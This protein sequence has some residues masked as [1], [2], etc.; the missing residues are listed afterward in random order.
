MNSFSI[1]PQGAFTL[2]ADPTNT[3]HAA[4]RHTP[5]ITHYLQ[6]LM[7]RRWLIVAC[8]AAALVVGVLATLLATPQFTATTQIEINREGARILNNVQNVEPETTT[9]DQEFYQTQ[10]TILRSRSLA[11]RVVKQLRLADDRQFF[12]TTGDKATAASFSEGAGASASTRAQRAVTA[13]KIVLKHLS[14]DP[15]RTSRLVNIGWTSPDAD[16]SARV[17]NA[18]ADSFINYNLERRF[19]ATTYARRFLEGRLEQLRQR[20]ERSERQLVGYATAQ[21]LINIPVSGAGAGGGVQERSLIVDRLASL[22]TALSE[23]IADRV[24]AESRLGKISSGA[25]PEGLINPAL[26]GMRQRRAEV[27]AEYAKLLAQFSPEYPPAAALAAQQRGLEQSIA[28]E[29]NRVNQTVRNQYNDSVSRE[30]RLLGQVDSLR[31]QFLDQRRRSI[32]YNIFQ[33]DV[34]TNRELYNGLLQRYKEIGVAGGIGENNIAVVDTAERADR[35]S[36]PRPV[37]NMLI[38]LVLGTLMGIGAALVREQ[39]DETISDPADLERRTGLPLLGGVPFGTTDDLLRELKDPKAGVT[40]A[41]L[42]IQNSLAFSTERGIPASI[43][44]TSTRPAEGKSTSAYALANTIARTGVRVLLIDGDMRSPSVHALL[45]LP[46]EH[47]LSSYLSGTDDLTQVIQHP[48]DEAFAV[49]TAGQQPPNAAEL[50]RSTRLPAL[51]TELRN[52]FDH[53]VIDAP[54]VMG[55][56]DAPILTSHAE[57]TVYVMEA[58]GVRARVALIALD[59]LKQAHARVLGGILTKLPLRQMSYGYGYEYGYDYGRKR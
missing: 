48:A 51:L 37:L 19:G 36:S 8:I 12:I 10:Y 29:E 30:Q 52:H 16:L 3:D 50:L 22:N 40:D 21:S 33:R 49:M 20:L 2:T 56:A 15:I 38:A 31:D 4:E 54:P 27:A 1:G 44:V 35:P 57:G 42:S 14:I 18:W 28:R 46:N 41:Y 23:A 53:V 55:L 25:S 11:D 13:A 26:N 6:T 5:L 59:R 7:R 47:G 9:G 58:R 17:A 32:Q 34:D 39:M 43:V 24:K 45:R